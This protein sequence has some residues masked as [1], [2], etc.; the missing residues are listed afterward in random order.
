MN[1]NNRCILICIHYVI[2]FFYLQDGPKVTLP[3]KKLNSSITG[4]VPG[5]I[6]LSIIKTCSQFISIK[7]RLERPFVKYHYGLKQ[8][9]FT[10]SQIGKQKCMM[11]KNQFSKVIHISFSFIIFSQTF[12]L[13]GISSARNSF[14]KVVF[15][16]C[17]IFLDV[18]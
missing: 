18:H 10:F 4:R 11:N 16:D 12:S 7:I 14:R 1:F 2:F 9:N 8:K 3:K 6:L 15:T 17:N 13:V 5:L